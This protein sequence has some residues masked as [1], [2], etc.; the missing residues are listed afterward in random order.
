MGIFIEKSC[1]S[2]KRMQ[3]YL[4]FHFDWDIN[5]CPIAAIFDMITEKKNKRSYNYKANFSAYV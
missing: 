3:F 5:L 2:Q 1:A 4:I